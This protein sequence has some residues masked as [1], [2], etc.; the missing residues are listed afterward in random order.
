MFDLVGVEGEI[1]LCINYQKLCLFEN[2][3]IWIIQVSRVKS[4]L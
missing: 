1:H 3:D 2:T 4:S